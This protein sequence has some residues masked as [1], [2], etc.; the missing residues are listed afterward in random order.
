MDWPDNVTRHSF[1]SY[2]LAKFRDAAGT[3]LEAGHTQEML[4]R[5][6]R[7]L[8]TLDGALITPELAGEFWGIK[9]IS[10]K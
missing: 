2:H 3:A 4:F 8:L 5:N 7:E 6:Y 10:S 1:C 9:P